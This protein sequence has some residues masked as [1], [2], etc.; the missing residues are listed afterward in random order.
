M[1]SLEKTKDSAAYYL[2]R[3]S[4][5]EKEVRNYLRRKG[6]D[7]E[8]I[9]ETILLFKDYGYINDRRYCRVFFDYAFGKRWGKYRI[10]AELEQ[11]GI[12][13]EISSLELEDYLYEKGIDD[14]F[15]KQ[16][17]MEVGTRIIRQSDINENQLPEKIKGRIVRRLQS[18]GY[19]HSLIYSVI[20][21]LER[22]YNKSEEEF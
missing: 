8:D 1:D 10:F 3:C 4:R 5:S 21:E 17:A 9:E 15:E 2:G 13:Q 22:I 14:N 20:S 18:Y 19:S 11:R 12:P 16:K 6:F 7:Q